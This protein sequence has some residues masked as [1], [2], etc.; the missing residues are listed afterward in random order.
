MKPTFDPSELANWYASHPTVRRMWALDD[1]MGIRVIVALEPTQDGDDVHPVWFANGRAWSNELQLCMN[2]TVQLEL[3]DDT[4]FAKSSGAA[5]DRIVAEW[6]WRDPSVS[7]DY[8]LRRA[9]RG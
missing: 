5:D 6:C 9:D 8:L 3:L 1:S 7:D 2:R 4:T